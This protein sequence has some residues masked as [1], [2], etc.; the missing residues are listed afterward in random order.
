MKPGQKIIYL[1][2]NHGALMRHL[3]ARSHWRRWHLRSGP[4]AT[5][6]TLPS[7]GSVD[8]TTAGKAG[9][10]CRCATGRPSRPECGASRWCCAPAAGRLRFRRNPSLYK[11]EKR[12]FIM[13]HNFIFNKNLGKIYT[14]HRQKTCRC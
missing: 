11:R 1:L 9:P 10:A 14:R 8:G 6:D 7:S 3:P 5:T 12:G 13:F 4:E 2:S